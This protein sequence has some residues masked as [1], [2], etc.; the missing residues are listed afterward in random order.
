MTFVELKKIIQRYQKFIITTHVNPDA[1][2]I[3]SELS[4]YYLLI[5]LHKDVRIINHNI[6][7]Y[8]LKFLD[9]DSVIEKYNHEIHDSIIEEA[10][11]YVVLDLSAPNRIVS[12]E[13]SLLNFDKTKICIDHHENPDPFFKHVVG[14]TS[15]SATGEIIYDFIIKSEIVKL[16]HKIAYQIYAAIMT[17]TGSFRFDKTSSKI[18][19]IIADLLSHNVN[20]TEIY[21]KIYDQS[22]FAKIKLLGEALTTLKLTKSKKI[23]YMT[24]SSESLKRLGAV[25]D[26]VDGFVN[27]CLS[28]KGVVIGILFFELKDGFKMSIRSKGT[29]PVNKLANEFEG[30][31]HRNAAGSRL[32]NVKM[33]NYIKPVLERA[34]F[35]LNQ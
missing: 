22:N 11:V 10:D 24:I 29:I 30:G 18:H 5:E 32:F 27:Y 26:D 8:N 35:Y 19:R 9:S 23:A 33:K 2:A 31:G 25:E 15:Y 4:F 3:G 7:P 6:T 13:K 12:M 21:D 34:E 14:D 20:P 28:I 17:D 1:D 16:N